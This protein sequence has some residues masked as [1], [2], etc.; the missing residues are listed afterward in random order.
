MLSQ[1]HP[2]QRVGVF[3][4]I[5]NMYYSARQLYNKKVNFAKILKT[6]VEQRILIRAFAYVIRADIK[7]EQGFFE[8]LEKIGFDVREK[9]LQVFVGGAKKGDWDVGLCMD[10]IRMVPKLDVIVLVSGDGDF[11]DMLHYV[12]A[13]GCRAEVIAFGR[14]A[15]RKLID[16]ADEF[17]DLD[18]TGPAYLRGLESKRKEE[19]EQK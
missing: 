8:A 11:A 16:E 3:V 1:M 7:E 12:K 10:V 9:E 6:A 17:F 18:K 19:A 5:Q 13:L 2:G 4:D 15:S 14:T